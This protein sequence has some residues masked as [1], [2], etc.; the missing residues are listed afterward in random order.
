MKTN[1]LL[2]K[3]CKETDRMVFMD[4]TDVMLTSDGP[5]ELQTSDGRYFNPALFRIDRIHLNKKGH[6]VWTAKMKETL[7]K[8][9]LQQQLC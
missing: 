5:E 6:D 7:R 9:G 1:E 3:M 8:L 4:A 2:Q